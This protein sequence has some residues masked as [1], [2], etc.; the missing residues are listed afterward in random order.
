[1]TCFTE[2]ELILAVLALL[3]TG[4]L[5]GV[6]ALELSELFESDSEDDF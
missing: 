5:L 1:M 3:T 4:A 2:F 6:V